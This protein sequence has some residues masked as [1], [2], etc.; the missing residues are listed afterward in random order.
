MSFP[1]MIFL[2]FFFMIRCTLSSLSQFLYL[3]S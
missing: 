2:R 1:F 3:S